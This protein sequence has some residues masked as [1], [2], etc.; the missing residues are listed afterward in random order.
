MGDG[1]REGHW[2]RKVAT[3]LGL[4]T[5]LLVI[6]VAREKQ[7][8]SSRGQVI[9]MWIHISGDRLLSDRSCL[10]AEIAF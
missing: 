8:L 5:R 6:R 1:K 4:W 2:V 3:S 10:M 7:Q 9:S